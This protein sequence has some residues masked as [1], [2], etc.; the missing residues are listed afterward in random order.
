MNAF[1]RT[2]RTLHR[3]GQPLWRI[4]LGSKTLFSYVGALL[5]KVGLPPKELELKFGCRIVFPAHYNAILDYADGI[6]QPE[7]SVTELVLKILK[8]GNVAVD[9]GAHVGYYTLLFRRLVGPYGRVY[10]FEPSPEFFNVLV[11]NLI[12][13]SFTDVVAVQAAVADCCGNKG[14]Y[15]VLGGGSSLYK[16][17]DGAN[18][19]SVRVT[20]LDTF[21]SQLN[22]PKIDL[23]KMDIEGAEYAALKGAKELV[24]RNDSLNML[25]ELNPSTLEAA[26]VTPREFLELLMEMGFR[27]IQVVEW[28]CYSIFD[29]E[30]DW[31]IDEV[32]CKGSVN[33]WCRKS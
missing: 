8:P 20:T 7:R 5:W 4:R 28:N 6:Y 27:Q 26:G 10:A 30:L 15:H 17:M 14:F 2:V 13:N 19:I 3:V 11:K 18:M 16:R 32:Y 21:F 1:W 12:V 23:V 22:W 29:M 25:V 31:L 33:L 9:V 24:R